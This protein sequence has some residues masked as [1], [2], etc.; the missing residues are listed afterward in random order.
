MSQQ[1]KYRF[2]ATLLDAFTEFLDVKVEEFFYQDE[3]G[4]WHINYNE[5]TGELHFSEEEV[6]QLAKQQL[7][8]KINRVHKEPSEAAEKGT[9]LNEIID[10]MIMKQPCKRDDMIIKTLKEIEVKKETGSISLAD[11]KPDAYDYWFE[12]IKTP[13]IYAH[14]QGFDFYFDI[15]F[16]RQVA[17]YFKGSICQM[18]IS[19]DIQTNYG[20]VELY[21][22][23]DYIKEN[24][25]YDLKTTKQYK[26]GKYEKSW[27]K[28]VYPYAL[29]KTGKCTEIKE[30]EYSCYRLMGGTPTQPLIK[31][32][33]FPEVY[34]FDYHTSE[35]LLKEQ[36][37]RF[38]EFIENN[39][40]VITDKKLLCQN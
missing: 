5:N 4:K 16:C 2:Y 18:P 25:V 31:G 24:K 32:M 6:Y 37:E 15:N 34:L 23:P 27:Q 29:I 3:Q 33:F 12:K 40:N 20:I 7:I 9:A 11:G 17:D 36:C 22:Y 26:F 10:C 19:V 14:S 39:K 8:D 35:Y 13:C 28:H 30:F 38:I 21:G 1:P